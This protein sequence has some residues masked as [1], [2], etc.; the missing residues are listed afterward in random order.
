[1]KNNKTL[2]SLSLAMLMNLSLGLISLPVTASSATAAEQA[3]PEKGPH[4]GR[5]LRDG[6]FALE[7]SIFETGVP[8]EFRVWLT[9][10]GQPIDPKSVDLNVKLTRL[11]N[12][13]DDINFYVQGDFLRGDM[14]IY[15]PHSFVVTIE[16][17]HQG[18]S[19]ALICFSSIR[20]AASLFAAFTR[21]SICA[22]CNNHE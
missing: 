4:R 1:M 5:M 6:D 18:K 11:G 20:V 12:V 14:E 13:V 22:C 3:E 9:K 2:S 8:P 7:L 21:L 15:E 10:E 17:K 19:R 16:A